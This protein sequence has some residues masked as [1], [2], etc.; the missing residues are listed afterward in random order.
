MFRFIFLYF[1]TI[2]CIYTVQAQP[3]ISPVNHFNTPDSAI[4]F[5]TEIEAPRQLFILKKDLQN[6]ERLEF[7][8]HQ[9]ILHFQDN[10]YDI[11]KWSKHSL[12]LSTN[13]IIDSKTESVQSSIYPDG[14]QSTLFDMVHDVTSVIIEDERIVL[15]HAYTPRTIVPIHIGHEYVLRSGLERVAISPEKKWIGGMVRYSNYQIDIRLYQ[16]SFPALWDPSGKVV[17][18][19]PIVDFEN[20][21]AFNSFKAAS[22]VKFSPDGNFFI[23]RGIGNLLIIETP[24]GPEAER[25]I[26]LSSAFMINTETLTKWDVDADVSFT[27]DSRYFVT[28]RNG[29]PSLVSANSNR[30]LQRYDIGN[31]YM[32]A[33]TFSNDDQTLYIATVKHNPTADSRVYIFPSQ[34]PTS[35]ADAWELY[36]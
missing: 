18:P 2:I 31:T 36:E 1:I 29:Y 16:V 21:R 33:A 35:H 22:E 19:D 6:D 30:V 24:N 13:E 7:G 8:Y 9:F 3:L 26:P 15:Q 11:V 10:I 25:T 28:L 20:Y 14:N 27:S 4:P 17:Y 12:D 23:A 34:L 5:G 32:L